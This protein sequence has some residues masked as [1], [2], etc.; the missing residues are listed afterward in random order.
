MC[1]Y[2]QY[3]CKNLIRRANANL[4][5]SV[6]SNARENGN[7][8]NIDPRRSNISN[9]LKIFKKLNNKI[10]LQIWLQPIATILTKK[11]NL[12]FENLTVRFHIF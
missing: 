4:F 9:C 3:F 1:D 5:I 12:Y 6:E 11:I 2:G 10:Y 8:E 7:S